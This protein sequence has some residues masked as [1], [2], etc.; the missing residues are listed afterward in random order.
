MSHLKINYKRNIFIKF[1]FRYQGITENGFKLYHDVLTHLI[2]RNVMTN[3]PTKEDIPIS[4]MPIMLGDTFKNT[5]LTLLLGLF[6]SI[7]YFCYEV[8]VFNIIQIIIQ[9]ILNKIFINRFKNQK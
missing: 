5:I 3:Y 8:T 2:L 4:A 1:I 9:K 7:A 6:I